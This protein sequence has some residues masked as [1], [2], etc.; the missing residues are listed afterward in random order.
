MLSAKCSFHRSRYDLHSR[1]G[2]EVELPVWYFDVLYLLKKAKFGDRAIE[3]FDN[4]AR[5]ETIWRYFQQGLRHSFT[6]SFG[7]AS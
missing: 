3:F 1:R 2:Y 5:D 4:D 7:N 6:H